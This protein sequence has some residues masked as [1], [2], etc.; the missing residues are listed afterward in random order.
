MDRETGLTLIVD[1]VATGSFR[2]G[3]EVGSDS[4]SEIDPDPLSK[5][6]G[7]D[8]VDSLFKT[9]STSRGGAGFVF[10]FRRGLESGGGGRCC[11]A[12]GGVGHC[13]GSSVGCYR[14]CGAG[15][16]SCGGNKDPNDSSSG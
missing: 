2:A 5:P 3:F 10:C 14:D 8:S 1:W 15:G 7:V 4:N 16:G 12:E 6:I 11:G 13:G 9:S